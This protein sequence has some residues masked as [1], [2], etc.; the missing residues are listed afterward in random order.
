MLF[1]TLSFSHTFSNLYKLNS[2]HTVKSLRRLMESKMSTGF[3]DTYPP[4][5]DICPSKNRALPLF[6]YHIPSMAPAELCNNLCE[7]MLVLL[8][9]S[10]DWVPCIAC[11]I[12]FCLRKIELFCT[13]ICLHICLLP[14]ICICVY[15]SLLKVKYHFAHWSCN[16]KASARSHHEIIFFEWAYCS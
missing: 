7:G 15:R 14:V 12:C 9:F 3:T 1:L 5:R 11:C 6:Y 2:G 10:K 16:A 8:Y 13:L 4:L